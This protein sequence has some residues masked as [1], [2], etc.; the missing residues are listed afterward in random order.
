MTMKLIRHF[1]C[2]EHED[3]GQLGWEMNNAG[4]AFGPIFI[5]VGFA[6]DILEHQKIECVE[7]EFEAL[8]SMYWLRYLSA[9]TFYKNME[10]LR[11][12]DISSEFINIYV[13]TMQQNG[14]F[15][16]VIRSKK[17]DKDT[18]IDLEFIVGQGIK[19][20]KSELNDVN[21]QTLSLITQSFPGYFRRGFR[22]AE[23]RFEFIGRNRACDLF[24]DLC[25]RFNNLMTDELIF[26]EKLEVAINLQDGII[27]KFTKTNECPTCGHY[28]EDYWCENCYE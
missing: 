7:D 8:G 23:K 10:P 12:R 26:G 21:P 15:K 25:C 22:N 17:L 2:K 6:H 20:L 11:L 27:E 9:Y 24:E 16:P 4:P 1:T 3:F 19:L 18:E 5:P 28:V 14:L 13:G